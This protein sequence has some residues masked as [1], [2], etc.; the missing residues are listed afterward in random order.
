MTKVNKA[1]AQARDTQ[2]GV[3]ERGDLPTHKEFRVDLAN[4]EGQ[5]IKPRAKQIVAAYQ[6]D[7]VPA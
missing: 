6:V 4:R 5:F 7:H 2:H 3:H 1:T